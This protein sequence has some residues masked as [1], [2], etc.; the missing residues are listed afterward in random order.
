[1]KM[2]LT[3]KGYISNYNDEIDINITWNAENSNKVLD[4]DVLHIRIR[5]QTKLK[6][7]QVLL[8]ILKMNIN[9]LLKLY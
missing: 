2:I 7:I 3:Q 5:I 4:K 1:M 8:K 6:E 9:V